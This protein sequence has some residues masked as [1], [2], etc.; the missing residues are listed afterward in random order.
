MIG[1]A[2]TNFRIAT[3]AGSTPRL[4]G[5]RRYVFGGRS[6]QFGA[7]ASVRSSPAGS[8]SPVSRMLSRIIQRIKKQAP[9]DFRFDAS[10][11]KR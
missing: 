3:T 4:S 6:G 2:S 7:Q 11:A 10:N 8:A 1:T 5:M 9:A